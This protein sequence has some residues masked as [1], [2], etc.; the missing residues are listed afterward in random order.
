MAKK[1]AQPIQASTNIIQSN[2]TTRRFNQGFRIES[3]TFQLTT[4]KL[5]K[6][7]NNKIN[8]PFFVKHDHQHIWRTFDSDGKKQIYSSPVGGHFH[9]ITFEESKNGEPAKVLSI[10]EPLTF[11]I[12]MVRGKPKKVAKPLAEYLEDKH[13][14]EVL[15]LKSDVVESRVQN[16]KAI[17]MIAEEAQKTAP[18]P[19]VLG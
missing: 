13:T 7:I 18:V 2:E 11:G 14:H 1:Q 9:E 5:I 17:N 15:Y 3:D 19:G 10:S 4:S 8:D 6:D 16:P 12:E